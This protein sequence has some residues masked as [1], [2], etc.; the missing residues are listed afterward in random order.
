MC[1]ENIFHVIVDVRRITMLILQ[2][3]LDF[4]PELVILRE[5]GYHGDL[6]NPSC[7]LQ[8]IKL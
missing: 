3:H 4:P 7:Q 8:F 2:L 5:D 6:E 1:F